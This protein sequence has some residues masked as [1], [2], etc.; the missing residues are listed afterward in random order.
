MVKFFYIPT[1]IILIFIFYILRM[2]IN[3]FGI[4]N[5]LESLFLWII[6]PISLFGWLLIYMHKL[7]KFILK[8]Y[9]IKIL[10][11]IRTFIIKMFIYILII[12]ILV[13]I[14]SYVHKKPY[15][16]SLNGDCSNKGEY[17]VSIL[18]YQKKLLINEII[19]H[20]K[21]MR[22]AIIIA[23]GKSEIE[24]VKYIKKLDNTYR[25]EQKKFYHYC[26]NNNVKY[27]K[28]L[29]SVNYGG[30]LNRIFLTPK[31]IGSTIKYTFD[32]NSKKFFNSVQYIGNVRNKK[33]HFYYS[34]SENKIYHQSNNKNNMLWKFVGYKITQS[35]DYICTAFLNYD[36][37]KK[38][39]FIWE[40]SNEILAP[41]KK[42]Q[43]VNQFAILK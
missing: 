25:K 6:L 37:F 15:H 12:F 30:I 26:E 27:C 8:P 29:I 10:S 34:D 2:L 23:D 5:F 18:K 3:P 35:G 16:Y 9:K 14:A 41:Q 17:S 39:Y 33:S 19:R 7:I 24:A 11:G 38:R 13:N 36:L 31:E 20:D 32:E 22:K 1:L 42:I 43:I 4:F 40:K 21:K 28:V